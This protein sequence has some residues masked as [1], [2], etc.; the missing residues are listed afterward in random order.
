MALYYEFHKQAKG[1]N[2]MQKN[3]NVIVKRTVYEPLKSCP[4]PDSLG[5]REMARMTGFDASYL[6]RVKRGLIAVTEEQLAQ[7]EA[8]LAKAVA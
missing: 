5:I 6:S 3:C 1:N 8:A 2:N 4:F 7:I